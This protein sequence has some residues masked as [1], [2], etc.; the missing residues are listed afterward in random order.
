[1]VTRRRNRS[2]EKKSA[3]ESKDKQSAKQQE[4]TKGKGKGEGKGGRKL[5]DNT[6]SKNRFMRKGRKWDERHGNE[7]IILYNEGSGE[8]SED[9]VREDNVKKYVTRSVADRVEENASEGSDLNVESSYRAE[10]NKNTATSGYVS[11]LEGGEGGG[12]VMEEGLEGHEDGGNEIE[13]GL[14]GQVCGNV[15][16]QA[17]EGEVGGNVMGQ[18][19]EGGQDS[20]NVMA[21][22]ST[23]STHGTEYKCR[24]CRNRLFSYKA[25]MTH[26][27]NA[28]PRWK[29]ELESEISP[30]AVA[31][32]G[33]SK[34]DTA[35]P[36]LDK[37]DE[38]ERRLRD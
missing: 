18:G 28:H 36:V 6:Q 21:Q 17:S 13:E 9:N 37:N 24:F 14:Q 38:E 30:A 1:M 29:E 27:E 32:L 33:D 23:S 35:V 15:M 2:H 10:E 12:N 26:I 11:Q 8:C 16:A 34:S 19:S 31:V 25:Y 7:V 22:G 3:E 20:G 4:S 5:S